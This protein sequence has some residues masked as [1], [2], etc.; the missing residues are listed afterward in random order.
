MSAIGAVSL[1][2]PGPKMIWH[3]GELGME[4]SLDTCT[5]GTV[6]GCRLDTKPQPQWV[7]NW[8]ANTQ[9]KKIYDDWSRMNALKQ[10]NEVFKGS[11]SINPLTSNNLAQRIYVWNETLSG[12][13]N[14]VILANFDVTR[15]SITADFP[16]TGTWH[17]LMDESTLNVSSTNQAISLA[18][19]EF[20]IYGNQQATLSNYNPKMLPLGLRQNPVKER[21]EIDLP[22]EDAYSYKLYNSLG[23]EISG[24]KKTT[25]K[26]LTLTAPKQK[27]L[28]FVLVKNDN[29][30][31][32]GICKVFVE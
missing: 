4:Q 21:I 30:Q 10:S 17:N 11:S 1:L 9:R 22:T 16:Y 12:L 31:L 23:Q 2:V 32:L 13:K 27:G 26:I 15:Q 18:P 14:V 24:T 25:G 20:K 6:D 3:F 5:D 28:Y 29:T 19:G 8:L 7:N